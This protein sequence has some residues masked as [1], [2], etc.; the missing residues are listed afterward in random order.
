MTK[1]QY[2]VGTWSCQTKLPAMDNMA[3]QTVGGNISF[4]VEPTNAIGYDLSAKGYSSAGFMGYM[5]QKGLWYS[6]GAD[7][8]GGT[9][10][11][12]SSGATGNVIVM[13]GNSTSRGESMPSRDTMTKMSDTKYRDLYEVQKDGKWSM[14]ADSMCTKTSNKPD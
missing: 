6:A 1:L 12:T 4:E 7:V 3:A 8:F 9:T 2:L 11:E 14:G 10:L 5:A 13:S